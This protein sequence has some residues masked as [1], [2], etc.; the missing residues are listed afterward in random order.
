VVHAL[1]PRLVVVLLTLGAGV[2]S[3]DGPGKK[4]DAS[5]RRSQVAQP[6][7]SPDA[8]E[9]ELQACLPD[10]KA[11]P[12]C[13][14]ELLL[15]VPP[16]L[17]PTFETEAE[18]LTVELTRWVGKDELATL[19]RAKELTLGEWMAVRFLVLEDSQ[20]NVRLLKVSFRKVL[21]E[22]WLHGFRLVDRDDVE[23]ELGLE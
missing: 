11:R 15:R 19:Y 6:L 21:G 2:A 12:K 4:I 9:A 10:F 20:G 5:V 16:R 17:V 23:K 8:W 22:W 13:L 18:R 1:L 7:V 3:A 14:T